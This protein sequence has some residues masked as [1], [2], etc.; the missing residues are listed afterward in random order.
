M[1]SVSWRTPRQAGVRLGRIDRGYRKT[2][3][4][5]WSI[6]Y[7]HELVDGARKE[8]RRDGVPS[9]FRTTI[10]RSDVEYFAIA[11][12][13]MSDTTTT[14]PTAQRATMR[15]STSTPR[16]GPDS[17]VPQPPGDRRRE[18]D[19]AAAAGD[20]GVDLGDPQGPRALAPRNHRQHAGTLPVYARG[21]RACV[22]AVVAAA[23][24]TM[25]VE[26]HGAEHGGTAR[27][28]ETSAGLSSSGQLR[29]GRTDGGT[30]VAPGDEGRNDKG[31]TGNA[32]ASSM[33]VVRNREACDPED[34]VAPNPGGAGVSL[35][36][37]CSSR[38]PT[39][40]AQGRFGD[41]R[42]VDGRDEAR[43]DV[44]TRKTIKSKNGAY[45]V[46]VVVPAEWMTVLQRWMTGRREWLF[47]KEL[48]TID[49]TNALRTIDP[50]LE[51]RSLRRGALQTLAAA[52]VSEAV[53]MEFEIYEVS[54]STETVRHPA[55]FTGDG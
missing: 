32:P 51:C 38:R 25:A 43:G 49:V 10:P 52:G 19:C 24:T 28:T 39:A 8:L 7:Q 41:R 47:S 54:R 37:L 36:L 50:L 13:E 27:R 3:V 16:S 11:P 29:L 42:D 20:G 23:Q 44:S 53:M 46:H 22:L 48:K 55:R 12:T 17:G 15:V 4:G 18:K 2:K 30:S 35:A 45:T 31:K 6:F 33:R 34:I 40:F 26:H 1:V 5:P 21:G 9:P 14:S